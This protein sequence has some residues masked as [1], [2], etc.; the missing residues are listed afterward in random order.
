MN[1]L[2]QPHLRLIYAFTFGLLISALQHS[3]LLAGLNLFFLLLLG[4]ILQRRGKN[5]ADYFRRWLSLN[6]FSLLIWLTLSW[7]I[8]P[9]GI[10]IN[11]PGMQTALLICLRMN[12]ILF[13]VWLFLLDI[14]DTLLVQAI[15]RLPLP[16]KLIRLFIL[17]VRYIALLGD[18]N[19]KILTAM[20]AR[21][22]RPGFNRHTFRIS[23]QRVALLLIHAFIRIEKSEMALKARA[24]RFESEH[25]VAAAPLRKYF[26]VLTAVLLIIWIGYQ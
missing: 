2:W 3:G 5:R 21:G 22:Y 19:R 18:T 16:H 6:S 25:K 9:Q 7:K 13:S 4:L 23:A 10:T 17:T 26:E 20:R 1:R 24:F 12:L 15:A 11:E 14:N 8:G